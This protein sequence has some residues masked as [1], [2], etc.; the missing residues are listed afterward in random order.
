M[1]YALKINHP[2]FRELENSPPAWWNNLKDDKDLYIDIRKGNTINVYYNG[3]SIIKLEW[4]G[5][6]RATLHFEYIPLK[7]DTNYVSFEFSNGDISLPRLEVMNIAN[8]SKTSL[9]GLKK[10]I[11]KFYSND[12]EKG[13][14][15][16]YVTKNFAMRKPRG[17]FLDTEFQ[18]KDLRVDLVW[19]DL[20]KKKLAFIELKTISDSRP[21]INPNSRQETI[22]KQLNK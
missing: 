21:N 22:D 13:L 4:K 7:G 14:Q 12:S 20:A 5:G 10:R 15:G 17:F 11:E 19:I 16:K 1:N 2:L 6:F 18:H 9:T 8:F 3:G